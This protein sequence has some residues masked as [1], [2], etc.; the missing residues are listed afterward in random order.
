MMPSSRATPSRL[1][2]RLH[3]QPPHDGLH[4]GCD[5]QGDPGPEHGAAP[6]PDRVGLAPDHEHR[7]QE[8][9][10]GE[11]GGRQQVAT[12][13]VQREPEDR[14]RDEWRE[15]RVGTAGRVAEHHDE[16]ED[17]ERG[18]DVE[19][20]ALRA[21]QREAVHRDQGGDDGAGE[22]QVP[23]PG[24]VRR[25]GE[26]RD[27]GGGERQE[28]QRRAWR[29]ARGGLVGSH[30]ITQ[31]HRHTS[32]SAVGR[33]TASSPTPRVGEA[34]DTPPAF[35]PFPD[36]SDDPS[37]TGDSSAPVAST[38]RV[39]PASRRRRITSSA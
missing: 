36:R 22:Q 8:G 39:R 23:D 4:G 18:D 33:P 13:A 11:H 7:Q 2:L 31:P 3:P 5:H 15:P 12:G 34:S 20:G 32:P 29:R 9:E 21:G 17:P 26:G 24:R 27:P 14:H 25:Q 37:R 16:R 28:R 30:E 35:Y 38:K 1:R 6:L 19:P 10:A